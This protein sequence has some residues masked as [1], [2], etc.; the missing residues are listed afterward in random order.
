MNG[1]MKEEKGAN[2]RDK[3][4]GKKERKRNKTYVTYNGA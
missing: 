2:K 1:R 4:I 3:D